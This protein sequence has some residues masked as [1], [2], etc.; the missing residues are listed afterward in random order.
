MQN[1]ITLTDSELNF[2]EWKISKL[3]ENVREALQEQ[4]FSPL[5]QP[6]QN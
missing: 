4:G 6:D 5:N 1:Q 3:L 2:L